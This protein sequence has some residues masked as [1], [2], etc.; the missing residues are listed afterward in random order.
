M[1]PAGQSRAYITMPAW[2]STPAMKSPS[3]TKPVSSWYSMWFADD[4][5]IALIGGFEVAACFDVA[6]IGEEGL[7]DFAIFGD[8]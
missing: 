8:P 1:T 4:P 6:A 3:A 7:A 5:V 2:C